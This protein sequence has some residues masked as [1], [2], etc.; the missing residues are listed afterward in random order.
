MSKNDCLYV[1]TISHQVGSGGAVLGQKLSERLG[2]PFV[3]REILKRV[4]EQLH[5]AEAE[6]EHRQER[7]TSFWGSFARTL[8]LFDPAKSLS[9][10]RYIPSDKELFQLESEYISRIAEKSPAIFLG[11]CGGYILRNHPRHLSVLVHAGFAARVKRLRELYQIS[12]GEA[13][14]LIETNDR[15]RSAYIHTFTRQDC[16]NPQLYDLCVNTTTIGLDRTVELVLKALEAKIG[17]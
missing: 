9:A 11:R 14:K 12:E 5:L 7:L 15:E 16:L 6:V 1:I 17:L 13:K 3:D 10:D 2:I 4:S 8:E